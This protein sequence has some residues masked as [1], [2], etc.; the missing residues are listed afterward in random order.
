MK[1]NMYTKVVIEKKKIET[2]YEKRIYYSQVEKGFVINYLIFWSI[3]QMRL[4][5][6]DPHSRWNTHHKSTNQKQN[7]DLL[8]GYRD[9]MISSLCC[10][11]EYVCRKLLIFHHAYACRY[12]R[13]RKKMHITK[14]RTIGPEDKHRSYP[15]EGHC[16]SNSGH[17]SCKLSIAMYLYFQSRNLWLHMSTWSDFSKNWSAADYKT[18]HYW[19]NWK[20]QRPC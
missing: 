9:I 10:W 5:S 14:S 16:R 11:C 8:W 12:I 6:I 2:L 4:Y 15:L 3:Y 18:S 13:S 20:Y 17:H 19:V 1:Y 7:T